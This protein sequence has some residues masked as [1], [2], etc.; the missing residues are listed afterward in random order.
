MSFWAIYNI[1]VSI[2]CFFC[3]V[4]CNIVIQYKQTNHTFFK[5]HILIFNFGCLLHVSNTRAHLQEDDCIYGYGTVFLHASVISSL[6]ARTVCAAVATW[7]AL[8]LQFTTVFS[9]MMDYLV[10]TTRRCFF[11]RILSC[12]RLTKWCCSDYF[13]FPC[14]PLFSASYP[15]GIQRCHTHSHCGAETYLWYGDATLPGQL[16]LCLLGWVRVTEVWVE[17]FVQDFWR[18]LAEVTPLSPEGTQNRPSMKEQDSHTIPTPLPKH[19]CSGYYPLTGRKNLPVHS[20]SHY[21]SKLG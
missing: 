7:D 4:Q 15:F 12:V 19:H 18:L 3:T 17:V 14:P 1:L 16:L 11:L 10:R 5:I 6:V 9:L 21:L 8:Y 20:H 13:H 2:W